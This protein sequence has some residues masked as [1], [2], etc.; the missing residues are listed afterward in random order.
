MIRQ[1]KQKH[2]LP[3]FGIGLGFTLSYLSLLVLIPLSILA[4][5]ALNLDWEAYRSLLIDPRTYAALKLTFLSS[6]IAALINLVF[7]FIVAWTLV[8]LPFPGSRLIDALIDL[9]FA[10]PTAVSGIALT[11]LYVRTGLLG[12]YLEPYG[13]QAAFAP[14]GVIIALTFIGLPFV[15]RTLQPA[16]QDIDKEYEEAAI[17]LG[18]SPFRVFASVIFPS[19]RPAMLTGFSLAFARA[20]GEY[21]SVVFISGNMPMKTEIVSLL[22]VG[23]MER[24]DYEGA[25]ALAAIT[26]LASFL[27]LLAINL[28]QW[29]YSRKVQQTG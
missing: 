26:L 29:H 10:L 22:I 8:R 20:L 2:F 11:S 19:I 6:L 24:F 16:L 21:G 9:P 3:G 4:V 15:V 23:K 12:R 25:T 7:G 14:L 17:S 27:I 5:K 28:T 13:V 1:I 18:A